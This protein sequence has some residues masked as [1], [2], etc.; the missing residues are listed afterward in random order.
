MLFSVAY[1]IR[2]RKLAVILSGKPYVMLLIICTLNYSSVP[3]AQFSF[4]KN[5]FSLANFVR[6]IR[7]AMFILTFSTKISSLYVKK[8]ERLFVLRMDKPS[9]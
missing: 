1:I 3:D 9:C 7:A 2:S 5:T 4:V 8:E 6:Y